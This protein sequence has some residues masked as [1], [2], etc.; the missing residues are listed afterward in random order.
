MCQFIP[1]YLCGSLRT[2][3]WFAML[4]VAT[5]VFKALSVISSYPIYV[6]RYVHLSGLLR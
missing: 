1:P 6:V 2:F 5:P 4:T 3:K